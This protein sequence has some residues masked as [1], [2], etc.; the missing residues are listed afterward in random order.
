MKIPYANVVHSNMTVARKGFG[1]VTHSILS[2]RTLAIQ[3]KEQGNSGA[4]M[5]C[6]KMGV[7]LLFLEFD[8][9]ED[10]KKWSRKVKWLMKDL[11]NGGIESWEIILGE[12]K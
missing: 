8:I 6:A 2:K 1:Y 10:I 12:R 5:A 11:E 3:L 7:D 4:E 9:S